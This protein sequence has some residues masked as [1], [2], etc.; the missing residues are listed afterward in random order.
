MIGCGS[1]CCNPATHACRNTSSGPKCMLRDPCWL[2]NCP[3]HTT[4]SKGTCM[5]ASTNSPACGANFTCCPY[6]QFCNKGQCSCP[7]RT[8]KCDAECCRSGFECV[9]PVI[10]NGSLPISTSRVCRKID[11]CAKVK[12]DGGLVCQDGQCKCAPGR[13]PCGLDGACCPRGQFCDADN[14]LCRCGRGFQTCADFC[15]P[16]HNETCVLEAETGNPLFCKV[17]EACDNIQCFAGSTCRNGTCICP[18]TGQKVCGNEDSSVCC[19]ADERCTKRRC[20]K[21]DFC[22]GIRC[23]HG[24]TCKRGTCICNNS[25]SPPCGKGNKTTCCHRSQ[26]CTSGGICGCAASVNITSCNGQCC[27]RAQ[28]EICLRHR[29]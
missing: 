4:C 27:D 8:S 18:A 2:A 3:A 16:Q 24:T 26:M 9:A 21:V 20:V 15:C 12:C 29:G 13:Q 14:G 17:K 1:Q 5:C 7:S 11:L 10:A 6:G 22:A 28:D 19:S 23:Q 25:T